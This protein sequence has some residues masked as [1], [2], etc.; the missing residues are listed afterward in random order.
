MPS[1]RRP[2]QRYRVALE[3]NRKLREK[4]RR[5]ERAFQEVAREWESF[6]TGMKV[7]GWKKRQKWTKYFVIYIS[8]SIK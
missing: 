6:L 7:N 5:M 1:K 4:I 8:L 3:E 2:S